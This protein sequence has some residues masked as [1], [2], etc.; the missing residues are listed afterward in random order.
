[1]K[2]PH[3]SKLEY[4]KDKFGDTMVA[5]T[6]SSRKSKGKGFQNEIM[7]ML[8]QAAKEA[9][10]DISQ[11]I[12]STGMGQPGQDIRLF[13]DAKRL[14][15]VSIECKRQETGY[16][17]PY[18]ALDQA[19]ANAA[20]GD[21]PLVFARI[22]KKPPLAILRADHLLTLLTNIYAKRVIRER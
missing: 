4:I 8:I 5:S 10:I 15:P 6:T 21:I 3:Q 16:A 17:K 20:P 13:G 18:E 1:M 14:F 9:N 19:I 7:A 11:L 22:N 12:E 2:K